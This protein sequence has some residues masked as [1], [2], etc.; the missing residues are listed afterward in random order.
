VRP[1]PLATALALAAI[2]G[3]LTADADRRLGDSAR[4]AVERLEATSA[5]APAWFLGHWGFQYYAEAAGARPIEA[6]RTQVEP[7]DVIWVPTN[8]TNVGIVTFPARAVESLDPVMVPVHPWL[9]TMDP[10]VGAGFYSDR[11]GP[12]PFRLGEAGPERYLM[13]RVTARFRMDR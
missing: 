2:F 6:G 9:R 8:N 11:W 7:G 3:L 1:I 13:Y 4:R 10:F 5:G 12:L